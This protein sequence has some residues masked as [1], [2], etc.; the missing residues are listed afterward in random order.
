MHTLRDRLSHA[1]ARAREHTHTLSLLHTRE[2]MHALRNR[3]T[4]A[5]THA[6]AR[7]HTRA[8]SLLHTQERMHALRV[9]L[10]SELERAT[11]DS[12]SADSAQVCACV[13]QRGRRCVCV[14]MPKEP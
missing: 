7:T 4:H 6:R 5:R 8:H 9:R 2:R 12:E 13:R 10:E 11:T 1:C 3:L 14:C